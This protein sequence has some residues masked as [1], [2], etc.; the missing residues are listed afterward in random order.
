MPSEGA[1]WFLAAAQLCGSGSRAEQVALEPIGRIRLIRAQQM[2]FMNLLGPQLQ[3]L[4]RASGY[5]QSVAKEIDSV[6]ARA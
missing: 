6:L 3:G 2:K 1:P 4:V 5:F